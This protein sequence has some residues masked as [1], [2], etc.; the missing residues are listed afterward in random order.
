MSETSEYVRKELMNEILSLTNPHRKLKFRCKIVLWELVVRFTNL[1]K[2][3]F[4][5]LVAIIL[6]ILLSP[7]YICTAIAIY[8]ESPGSII[9]KQSRVGKDGKHFSFYKFRSMVINAEKLKEKLQEQNE[10][11]DGVIFKMK[12]DPRITKIGTI[13]R[14]FSIDELPQLFNVLLGDMS[15]VGP[16]PPV[17]KEVAEYSL[18]DRKRLHVIPGITCIWQ[19]SGRSDIPFNQQVELDKEYI[20]SKSLFRDLWILLKTVP[21]V[22]SGKGA[23]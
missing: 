16:R 6:I 10:S 9:F 18:E 23:Y 12:K 22:L 7:V 5:F 21:A 15:L 4:D 3:S 20:R 1:T 2:R 8:I 19:V 17:P 13:I 11:G 14:K